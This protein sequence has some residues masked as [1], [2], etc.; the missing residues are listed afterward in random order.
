[1]TLTHLALAGL[2]AGAVACSPRSA[3]PRDPLQGAWRVVSMHLVAPDGGSTELPV[4]ESLCLFAN[5]YYSINYTFGA[6]ASV[7]YQ[8]RWHPSDTE[9]VARFS[10]MIV[11]AGSYRLSGSRL[12]ARPLFALAPEYVGGQGIFSHALRAD[13]LELTWE[14]SIASDGLEYPSGGTVT[15]LRLVRAD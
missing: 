7:P 14:Q 11:N 5:G 12:D 2:V 9:K 15:R 6:G 10:S 8:E 13:T 3:A 1:M 4:R